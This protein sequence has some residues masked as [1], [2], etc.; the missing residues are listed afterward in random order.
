MDSEPLNWDPKI[1]LEV[2]AIIFWAIIFWDY[3]FM[4]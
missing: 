4:Y 2:W 1:C 3:L